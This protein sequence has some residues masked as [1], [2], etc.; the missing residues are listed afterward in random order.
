MARSTQTESTSPKSPT[1]SPASQPN[2][3]PQV[4]LQGPEADVEQPGPSEEIVIGEVKSRPEPEPGP[5]PVV[6]VDKDGTITIK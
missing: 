2:S 3:N 4:S 5:A 6:S 1:S